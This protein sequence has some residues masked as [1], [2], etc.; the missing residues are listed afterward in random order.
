MQL[1]I[2]ALDLVALP[3]EFARAAIERLHALA[4]SGAIEK[5]HDPGRADLVAALIH[6]RAGV[7][8]ALRGGADRLQ[9]LHRAAGDTGARRRAGS[10]VTPRSRP[11]KAKCGSQQQRAQPVRA[12]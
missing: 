9:P 8:G 10:F 12:L 7:V 5:M 3:Y 6:D 1:R 4:R 11:T 2:Q